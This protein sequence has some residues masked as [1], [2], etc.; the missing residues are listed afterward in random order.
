MSCRATVTEDEVEVGI[1]AEMEKT[2][3]PESEAVH[4]GDPAAR[5]QQMLAKNRAKVSGAT[6]YQYTSRHLNSFL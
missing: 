6:C 5:I 3:L 4:G 1:D 2:V